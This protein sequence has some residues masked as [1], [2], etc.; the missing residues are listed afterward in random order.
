MHTNGRKYL[1][2]LDSFGIEIRYPA[3]LIEAEGCI[4][5]RDILRAADPQMFLELLKQPPLELVWCFPET[6]GQIVEGN[7]PLKIAQHPVASTG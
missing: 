1:K 3:F 6:H 5:S 7:P 4:E 2:I